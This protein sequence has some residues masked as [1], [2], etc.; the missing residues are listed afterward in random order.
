MPEEKI[1]YEQ[2]Q[3]GVATIRKCAATMDEIF[4]N[5]TGTMKNMTSTENFQGVA[6]DALSGEF[7]EFKGTFPSYIE[8]VNEFAKAYEAAA[9]VLKETEGQMAKKAEELE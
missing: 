2:V 5:V 7:E 1:T 3:E 9:A 8:K 4:N 6:S